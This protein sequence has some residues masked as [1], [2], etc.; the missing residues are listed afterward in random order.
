M[1]LTKYPQN[2]GARYIERYCEFVCSFALIYLPNKGWGMGI[3]FSYIRKM[4]EL[5]LFGRGGV[6][7]LDIGSS[8]LYSATAGEV[9]GFLRK[10]G[11]SAFRG[12]NDFSKCLEQGSGYDSVTGR[13]N[14]AFVGELLEAAG[15]H[16]E[17]FDIAAG[18]RT[19]VLDL[20]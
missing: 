14:E 5:G 7:V 11:P 12:I 19:T 17:S 18:Y 13:R 8:N 3:A 9:K 15:M 2:R 20:N 16:D 10:Y 6:N 4:D 1:S